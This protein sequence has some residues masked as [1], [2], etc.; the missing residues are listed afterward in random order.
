M[1]L[2]LPVVVGLALALL[3]GG[4]LARLSRFRLKAIPLLYG[5]LGLQLAAFPVHRGLWQTPDRLAIALWL[6]S[7]ACL[8]VAAIRNL[9]VPGVPLVGL[10]IAANLGAILSNGGHMPALPRALEAA[11]LHYDVHY[12]SAADAT[13]HLAMLVDRFAAPAWVPLAN[14]YSI[15]D[16]LIAAGTF[17]FAVAVTGA[18]RVRLAKRRDTRRGREAGADEHATTTG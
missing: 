7:Y 4:S 11:G 16:V 14:V 1:A 2:A 15:G 8:I 12:N 18:P 5:A 6:I 10:G 17:V 3:L 9:D 13:P